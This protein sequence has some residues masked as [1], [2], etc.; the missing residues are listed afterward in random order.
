MQ[1]VGHTEPKVTLGIY[2]KVMLRR[3]G[4][5]D[6]LIA[7][8][9]GVDWA[10]TGTNEADDGSASEPLVEPTNEKPGRGGSS[11]DGR[12]WVRT[13]DLSRVRRSTWGCK[14]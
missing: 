6:R 14:S 2:A 13:S 12:G 3:D 8:A 5:R 4:E 7:L 11:K 1:Q 9:D 10:Q